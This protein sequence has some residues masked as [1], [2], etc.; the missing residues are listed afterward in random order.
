[1]DVLEAIRDRRSIRKFKDTDVPIEVLDELVMH[2]N[3]APS[4][5][6][7]QARDFIIVKD[8]DTIK[9]LAEAAFGQRF[10][11]SA[12]AVIVVCGNLHRIKPY[13]ERGRRMYIYHD[14]AGAVQNILLAA[15]RKA[16]A[17]CWI[18]AFDDIGVSEALSLPKDIV[19]MAVIPVGYPDE[20]PRTPRR[21]AHS[22][23]THYE[24]W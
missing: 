24:R 10:I 23:I 20:K 1:M 22:V 4:A 17:T 16:L 21:Y 6:N 9:K 11:A 3:L 15:H 13:G 12:P 14:A 5:G 2:G 19:P 8:R 7:L 18:G